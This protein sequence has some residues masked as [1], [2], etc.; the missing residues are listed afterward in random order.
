MRNWRRWL[1]AAGQ[2]VAGGQK[3]AGG[4]M[5]ADGQVVDTL[6]RIKIS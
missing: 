2:L 4:Q 5:V 6:K 3:V 1:V